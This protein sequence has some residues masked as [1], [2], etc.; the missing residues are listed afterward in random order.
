M[1]HRHWQFGPTA[2][3]L[4]TMKTH[5]L[6]LIIC[7]LPWQ[8]GAQVMIILLFLGNCFQCASSWTL[9][10]LP[11]FNLADEGLTATAMCSNDRGANH[12]LFS[13]THGRANKRP[14]GWAA[15]SLKLSVPAEACMQLHMC[16]CVLTKVSL[17]TVQVRSRYVGRGVVQASRAGQACDHRRRAKG[18][19]Q[20]GEIS[21][22][23]ANRDRFSFR[24]KVCLR[25]EEE[26]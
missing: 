21:G 18:A 12:R 3:V 16:A 6:T 22:R 10:G 8:R 15:C 2:C 26:N 7:P 13:Q 5:F 11:R 9:K 19:E 20:P 24:Y 1:R 14:L 25:E 23:R 17:R 4:Y